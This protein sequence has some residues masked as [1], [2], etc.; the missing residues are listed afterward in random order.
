MFLLFTSKIKET[1]KT[2]QMG[3]KLRTIDEVFQSGSE[4]HSEQLM[5]RISK[6]RRGDVEQN[7]YLMNSTEKDVEQWLDSQVKYGEEYTYRVFVYNL[8]LG[9]SYFYRNLQT[10]SNTERQLTSGKFNV[11]LNFDIGAPVA[12]FEVEY[13]PLLLLIEQPYFEFSGTM[14]DGPPIPPEIE[15]VSYIGVEDK[16]QILFRSNSGQ[17][18]EFPFVFSDEEQ[19]YLSSLPSNFRRN[20]KILF[21]NDDLPSQYEVR[22]IDYKPNN[23]NDFDI[24]PYIVN[25]KNGASS[26]SKIE[27]IVPNKKY[28]YIFRSIDRHGHKSNPSDIYQIELINDG[29]FVY[30]DVEIINL[31]NDDG[32]E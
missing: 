3:G 24:E 16:I 8:I 23:L 7:F 4:C 11:G 18:Y 22:R 30:L 29:G 14:L 32:R 17:R 27:K 13:D 10:F 9:T 15:F 21:R 1:L 31:K 5:F 19:T 28:F 2:R 6:S 26:A 12:E 20:D 25:G